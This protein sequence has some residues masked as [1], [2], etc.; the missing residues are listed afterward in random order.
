MGDEKAKVMNAVQGAIEERAEH[1]P[2]LRAVAYADL[3][4]ALEPQCGALPVT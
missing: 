2:Q 4:W 1:R 3:V